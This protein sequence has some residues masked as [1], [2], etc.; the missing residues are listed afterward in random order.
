MNQTD[1]EKGSINFAY[2]RFDTHTYQLTPLTKRKTTAF[3]FQTN[4][5]RQ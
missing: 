2:N 5:L 4:S 1:L 3:S